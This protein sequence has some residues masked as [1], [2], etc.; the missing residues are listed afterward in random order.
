MNAIEKLLRPASVAV[1]GASAD[2]AKTAGRPI[3]YL[4]KHGFR[5]DIYPVNPRYPSIAGLRCYED[6]EALPHAP[7]VGIVLLGADRAHVAVQALAKR[8]TAAAIVLASGYAETGEAGLRRQAQLKDAA[9]AMRVLGP[10]TIGVV[11]LADRVTL[12]ASGALDTDD[13]A[14]GGVSVVSQSGGILGALL[15][16]AAD[17]GIGLSKLVSTSNEVDLDVSDFI[18]YFIGD[19][20]TSVI[21]LYLEGLRDPARFRAAAHAAARAGK[22]IVVYKIGRSESGA[23]S[24]VSH[25]GALAG[26]DRMYDALFREAGVIRAQTFGDLLD[27]PNALAAGRLL[28]GKRVA[29]LTST[30]GAG[31]LVADNLGLAG[32]DTPAPDADTAAALRALQTGDH[33]V[34]DRNPIDVTL[35]GLQPELLRR[36]IQTLAASPSYDAV[37]VIAG[38]SSI[39]MPEL[40][41]GAVRDALPGTDKPVVAFVSPHA[42]AVARAMNRLGVPAFVAPES[43][44]SAMVAM[45]E[46]AGWRARAASGRAPANDAAPLVDVGALPHGPLDEAQAKALF[47]R[48]GVTPVREQAVRNAAEAVDAARRFGERVVLKLLSNRVTHKS[49]I[50]GVVVGVGTDTIGAR[51]DRMRADVEAGAGFAPDAFLV[52]EMVSG[53]VETIVG[54]QRDPLGT[55]I[56]LGM[57][58]VT[59]EI[60]ND[61]VLRMLP[62]GAALSRDDALDMIRALR[63]WPLLDGY[64]GRP[65]AD[66]DALADALV[67]FSRM[68][69]QLDARL[70]EAE[71]NPLFVLEAGHGVRAADGVAILA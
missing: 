10:N 15:S 43:V 20:A 23:R 45:R 4:Q 66:V 48:F 7:D 11:N 49:D 18:D 59:A 12:S 35:A 44:A 14:V 1:I 57:G 25:T 40:M 3:A 62:D 21:A 24:A 16:R 39:G 19:D 46:A 60:F 33:A 37:A 26:E 56:L 27:V 41:A 63:T 28:H 53:G 68:A 47:A 54:L 67:A 42:P 9:G 6:V 22:P 2:P 55:A 51:L 65:K 50:G 69:A 30:G 52:Q 34:L 36:A 58:G 5:G 71:I 17:R 38:S 8:G 70:V 61:T 13:F 29:I 64:R 32:F 31:T